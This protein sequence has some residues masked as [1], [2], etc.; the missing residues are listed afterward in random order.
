MPYSETI[1]EGIP[2]E[3]LEWEF[4]W[5]FPNYLEF[6]PTLPKWW[7]NLESQC[8]KCDNKYLLR[9]V[10]VRDPFRNLSKFRIGNDFYVKHNCPKCRME[11]YSRTILLRVLKDQILDH[12]KKHHTIGKQ[13]KA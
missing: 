13:E 5:G 3:W 9:D 10:C 11:N 7:Q 12:I 4:G 8:L 2:L 6:K 1:I